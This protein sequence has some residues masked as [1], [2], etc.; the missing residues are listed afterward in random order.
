MAGLNHGQTMIAKIRTPN[1]SPV[2]LSVG[3][4]ICG[5]KLV[6]FHPSLNG[7]L[8]LEARGI[9]VADG[10]GTVVVISDKP[11]HDARPFHA[12]VFAKRLRGITSGD[13]LKAWEVGVCD[14]QTMDI[15]LGCIV[16]C[17]GASHCDP[18][19]IIPRR[20]AMTVENLVHGTSPVIIH[21]NGGGGGPYGRSIFETLKKGL[22]EKKPSYAGEPRI[23]DLTIATW[24]PAGEHS[25]NWAQR[26]LWR[27]GLDCEVLSPCRRV[28]EKIQLTLGMTVSTKYVMFLDLFDVVVLG[29]PRLSIEEMNKRGCKALFASELGHFPNIST[30]SF[31]QSKAVVPFQFLN[32]GCIVAEWDYLRTILDRERELTRTELALGGGDQRVYKVL[33]QKYFPD[34][35]IEDQCRVFQCLYCVNSSQ[36][37]VKVF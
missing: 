24:A 26:S 37:A 4:G 14:G 13:Q 33:Y 5:R 15:P 34:I 23:G 30:K 3:A 36:V 6:S 2:V 16:V 17:S 8:A 28:E 32:S 9:V 10:N 35:Q 29:D 7:C 25:R 11:V 12:F 21:R 1:P 19:P 22:P 20:P 18:G 27:V 31:E